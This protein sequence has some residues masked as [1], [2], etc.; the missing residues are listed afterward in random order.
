MLKKFKLISLTLIISLIFGSVFSFAAAWA[1]DPIDPN[2]PV[3][4]VRYDELTGNGTL[5]DARKLSIKPE[6]GSI[7]GKVILD[8]RLYEMNKTYVAPAIHQNEDGFFINNTDVYE[9]HAIGG[10][11]PIMAPDGTYG[12]PYIYDYELIKT[13]KHPAGSHVLT[14]RHK[15]NIEKQIVEKYLVNGVEVSKAEYEK[16][17]VGAYKEKSSTKYV[18]DI[19]ETLTNTTETYT[20]FTEKQDTITWSD[21]STETVIRAVCNFQ[22]D[23]YYTVLQEY[24]KT[25]ELTV[26]TPSSYTIIWKNWDN[27]LLKTDTVK[28]GVLPSYSGT[29]TRPEDSNYTYTFKG[30]A[31]SVTAARANT[32]YTAQY[33]AIPKSSGTTYYTITWKNWDNSILKTDTVK[34]GVKPSYSGTPTR[35][36]DSNY[37]YTFKGWTPSV[38]AASANTTYTA[39]YTATPK[40]SGTTYYTIIWK[41]WD[42]SILKT[43]TVDKGTKPSYS[44]TPTRPSDSNYTYTFKG[45]SPTIVAANANATYTAQYTAVP[46]TSTTKYTIT[47]KNWDGSVLKTQTVSK[48]TKPSYSGTPTRPAD[49]KY[50]Y[51]FK[52]WSPTVVAANSNA[53]YTAQYT[54]VAKTVV[55]GLNIKVNILTPKAAKKGFTAKWK[56]VSKT[57]LKKISGYQI[58]YSTDKN[59]VSSRT[60]K[61]GK[62]ATSKKFSK[63]KGKTYYYVRIRVYNG[64]KFGPWSTVKKIKTK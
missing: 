3:I 19:S 10:Q 59:F 63:L 21:G 33:T 37:T 9:F 6:K 60:V 52:G 11:T 39:Q 53:T 23:E 49:S 7:S 50:T 34:A 24:L 18:K 31:P 28:A 35:P 55:Q 44:G 46:K 54:A 58:Q 64:K 5:S 47:W 20:G 51:T 13:S 32:T 27:S 1:S 29:P 12:G 8:G 15:D 61:A 4:C 42:G 48:G 38:T 56:K 14:V 2:N 36:E 40:S 43:Q 17:K 30:W 57:N 41:N 25:Y 16:S 26:E 22:I 45:W 62:K